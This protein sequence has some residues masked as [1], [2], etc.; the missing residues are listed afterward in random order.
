MSAAHDAAAQAYWT[1]VER[2]EL[3]LQRC[4]ACSRSQHY[5]R[6]VCRHCGAR[7]LVPQRASGAGTVHAVTEVHRAPD[8]ENGRDPY[9]LVLV[10]LDEGPR[11]LTHLL[12]EDA[13]PGPD[14]WIGTSV[15][16]HVGQI[17]PDGP[18]VPLARPAAEHP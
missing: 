17:T 10:E 12:A 4:D 9:L 3:W 14:G 15:V 16:L 18:L 11:V 13:D 8:P 6:T 5:P 7:E 1:G 2:G